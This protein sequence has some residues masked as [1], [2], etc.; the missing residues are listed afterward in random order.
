VWPLGS[1]AFVE[2]STTSERA[3]HGAPRRGSGPEFLGVREYRPGDSMRHVHWPSTARTGTVMV[4]EFEE[5]RTRR[6]AIVVDTVADAGHAWTPLDACCSAAASIVLAAA[7][8]G[9]GARLLTPAVHDVEVAAHE[10]GGTLLRRLARLTATGRTLAD[11]APELA[12]GLR[13]AET[14]VVI[15][16]TWRA[17]AAPEL[18][19]ALVRLGA[20]GGRI[21]VVPVVLDPDRDGRFAM[22]EAEAGSLVADLRRT[23]FVAYPWRRDED[24]PEAFGAAASEPVVGAAR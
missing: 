9:Q 2:A 17:N 1:L 8:D 14:V 12:D 4:R 24:L 7:A 5:E 22:P 16:P 20:Q 10:D 15:A 11:A 21:V 19:P 23:G 18:V 3:L 6:I 13:G